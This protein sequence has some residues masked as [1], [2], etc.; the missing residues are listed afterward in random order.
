M[1]ISDPNRERNGK[2][3]EKEDGSAKDLCGVF[4]ALNLGASP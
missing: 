3:K 1:L 4:H 2:E